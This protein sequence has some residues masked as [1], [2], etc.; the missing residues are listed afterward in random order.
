MPVRLVLWLSAPVVQ[1]WSVQLLGVHI[2]QLW[3]TP[4]GRV[5]EQEQTQMREWRPRKRK[6]KEE[7]KTKLELL[8]HYTAHWPLDWSTTTGE[9]CW[10]SSFQSNCSQMD[11]CFTAEALSSERF[12]AW[13]PF[14]P[15]TIR[16]DTTWFIPFSQFCHHFKIFELQFTIFYCLVSLSTSMCEVQF[17]CSS[18]LGTWC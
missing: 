18:A 10:S 15:F 6:S 7:R 16:F 1:H 4:F 9:H 17:Q 12:V 2:Q 8:L 3:L 11:V 14:C 5:K 13:N